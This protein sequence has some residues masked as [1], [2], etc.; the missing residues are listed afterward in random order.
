MLIR[1]AYQDKRM[2]DILYFLTLVTT[3]IIP[4][5]T[6]TGL[7]G[8]NFVDANQAVTS[9]PP[10]ELTLHAGSLPLISPVRFRSFPLPPL[11]QAYS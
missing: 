7:Y 11:P 6:L 2:N 4:M 5:Q 3:S 10:P 1:Q 8:M 9:D